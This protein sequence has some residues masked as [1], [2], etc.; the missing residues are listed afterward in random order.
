MPKQ[1]AARLRVVLNP[2]PHLTIRPSTYLRGTRGLNWDLCA[3]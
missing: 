3:P 1:A 2:E